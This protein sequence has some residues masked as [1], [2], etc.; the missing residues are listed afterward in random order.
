MAQGEPVRLTVNGETVEVEAAATTLLLHVLRNDF[1]LNGPKYGCGLA[2]C[3]ACSV[4]IDDK[5]ARACILPIGGLQDRQI[6]TLEGLGSPERPH[7]IQAAFI[8]ENATQCGYCVNGMIMAAAALL[9]RNPDPSEAEIRSA[10][11]YNLCR[12]GSHVEVLRAIRRAARAMAPA[13][14][15]AE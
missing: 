11:R 2:Q 4:L 3:G 13:T 5:V 1:A 8:A 6:V 10:L 9:K 15:A 7:P 14:E 12:C